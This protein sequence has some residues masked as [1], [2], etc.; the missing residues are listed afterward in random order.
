M[1]FVLITLPSSGFL[2]ETNTFSSYSGSSVIAQMPH[3][4]SLQIRNYHSFPFTMGFGHTVSCQINVLLRLLM[5]WSNMVL[6][7]TPLYSQY[8]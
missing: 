1:T 7:D 6:L 8:C 3:L 4:S 2:F 5:H